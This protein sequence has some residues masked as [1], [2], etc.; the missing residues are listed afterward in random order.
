MRK[1]IDLECGFCGTKFQREIRH[2]NARPHKHYFCSNACCR[3]FKKA[4]PLQS[5]F[6]MECNC[7]FDKK[8][9]EIK[10]SNGNFCSIKCSSNRKKRTNNKPK[11]KLKKISYKRIYKLKDYTGFRSGK[12]TMLKYIRQHIIP[13]GRKNGYKQIWLAQCD[14]GNQLEVQI[15]KSWMKSSCINCSNRP[16]RYKGIVSVMWNRY[17]GNYTDGDISFDEFLTLTK[18]PCYYCG[19]QYSNIARSRAYPEIYY[20]NGLDRLDSSLPHNK[21]NCVPCCKYCN[22]SKRDRSVDDFINHCNM[23]SSHYSKN[24][25]DFRHQNPQHALIMEREGGSNSQENIDLN[26][27]HLHP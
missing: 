11:I 1:L 19:A 15:S 9:S 7:K 18:K 5:V 22:L 6:C 10:R 2:I 23:V 3:I 8:I 14:C 12:L 24:A 17:N 27:D 13:S 20:H 25:G 4:K 26:S 16:I 21:S